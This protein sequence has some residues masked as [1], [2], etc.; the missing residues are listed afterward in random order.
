MAIIR[1]ERIFV[2]S[3]CRQYLTDSLIR[4]IHFSLEALFPLSVYIDA[5][6]N[7][8]W[9]SINLRQVFEYPSTNRRLV[10]GVSLLLCE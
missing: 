1:E 6:S 2:T 4:N 9:S 7:A 10:C 8:F 3:F 5:Q